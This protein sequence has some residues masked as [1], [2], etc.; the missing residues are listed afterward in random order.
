MT[1]LPKDYLKCSTQSFVSS[2]PSFERCA[3]A[4]FAN[5]HGRW[6]RA[7]ALT[8]TQLN[9]NI[10]GRYK[11]EGG[12]FRTRASRRLRPKTSRPNTVIASEHTS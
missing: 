3:F 6:P 9:G 7:F 5:A 10:T 11:T 12:E 8:T 1:H 2:T 4:K